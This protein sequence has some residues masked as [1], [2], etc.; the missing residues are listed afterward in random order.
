MMRGMIL[1]ALWGVASFSA[2]A[3]HALTWR[4]LDSLSTQRAVLPYQNSTDSM[5]NIY[6]HLPAKR[7]KREKKPAII[8]IHGGAWTGGAPSTFAAYTT[9]FASRGL[10]AFSISYTLMK[11][12]SGSI[13]Q[14]LRD[15]RDAIR[16]IVRQSD[17]L[18]VDTNRLVFCGE[19]AGG[20]LAAMLA[21][22]AGEHTALQSGQAVR[23][24]ALILLNP[25]VNLNTPIFLKFVDA[26]LLGKGVSIADSVS[27]SDRYREKAI[28]LSPLYQVHTTL[29]PTFLLNGMDD[30]ITPAG[31]A[32]AFADRLKALGT[33]CYLELLPGKRHAFAVPH[34]KSTEQDV[35]DTVK[36]MDEFLVKLNLLK[37]ESTLIHGHDPN[38]IHPLK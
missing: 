16:A 37:G 29:S 36:A 25:V 1:I 24:A 13:D 7:S 33:T 8:F 22:Q 11:P 10:A 23:S 15:C 4:M 38:W 9:Y 19:S 20:H 26:K 31:E 14:C 34:Y 2:K 32:I 27:R 18:G 17:Q 21:V 30:T 35:I 6:Y 3:Q 28:R 12:G 5:L